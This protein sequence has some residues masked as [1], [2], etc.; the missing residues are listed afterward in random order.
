MTPSQIANDPKDLSILPFPLHDVK[1]TSADGEIR[2]NLQ[3]RAYAVAIFLVLGICCIGTY[4]AVSGFMNANPQGLSLGLNAAASETPTP[5][6]VV[7]ISTATL[8]SATETPGPTEAPTSTP[9]G[10]KP[11]PTATIRRGP[12]LD[13]PTAA[14]LEVT[15]ATV[16]A[17]VQVGCG[18]PFCGRIGQP[19]PKMAP[20]G[21]DCPTDY[22]WGAVYDKAGTGLPNWQIRYQ[23]LGGVTDK[24]A[25]KGPPD[26]RIG[27]YDIPVG[28]GTWVLQLFD[29]GGNVKS[30]PFQVVSRQPYAGGSTCPSRVD[31]V[32]Q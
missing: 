29:S 20:T 30:A 4:V 17:T 13:L 8:E 3:D 5:A 22:L 6:N 31:F 28:S 2:M 27:G 19:D 24:V 21:R 23:Q 15:T 26:T 25:T 18:F 9:K 16:A 7:E 14:P 1:I 10:F 12:T 11:S 32:Q